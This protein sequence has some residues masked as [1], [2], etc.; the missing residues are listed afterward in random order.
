MNGVLIACSVVCSLCLGG[1][2]TIILMSDSP[3]QVDLERACLLA[4]GNT[5]TTLSWLAPGHPRRAAGLLLLTRDAAWAPVCA[6]DAREGER[7]RDEILDA[8]D[9][10]ALNARPLAGR[11]VVMLE[12][13]R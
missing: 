12:E 3:Q 11:L 2:A 13:R 6:K 4:A 7:L 8:T 1:L 10:D 5:R 9:G